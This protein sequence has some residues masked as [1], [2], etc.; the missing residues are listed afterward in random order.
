MEIKAPEPTM[1]SQ[2]MKLKKLTEE[3]QYSQANA[4]PPTAGVRPPPPVT[5]Y[6]QITRQYEQY[7][8]DNGY[9]ETDKVRGGAGNFQR[10]MDWSG[11]RCSY[12]VRR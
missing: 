1:S 7:L 10:T 11:T 12:A 6:K 8:K 4:E 3:Y 5:P 9:V 2:K